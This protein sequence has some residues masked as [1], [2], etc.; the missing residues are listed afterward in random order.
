MWG[1]AGM[2]LA[3]LAVGIAGLTPS[4]AIAG[5]ASKS[6]AAQEAAIGQAGSVSPAP[7]AGTPQLYPTS[8][9]ETVRQ[10]VQCGGTMY[11]V[12]T[13]SEIAQGSSVYA[14]GNIFSFSATAPYQ[15]TSWNPTVNGTVNTIAF[16]GTDCSHA[17][18]GGSFTTV[19][20]TAAKNIAE[21]S[22]STGAVVSGWGHNANGTVRTLLAV[23]GHVLAGG[24]FTSINGSTK[25]PYYASLLTSTGLDD[26]YLNLQISGHLPNSS[27]TFVYNQ[28]LS[29]GGD[30]VLVEG[31]FTSVGGQSR[32]QIFMVSLN[33]TQGTVTGWTSTQFNQACYRTEPFY[34]RA[35]AWSPTDS[36]VYVADTGFHPA[37]WS[38]TFPLY[39]LCD[40]VAAFPS[41]EQTVSPH[42]INYTGCDSLYSVAADSST[43]Y[44]GGHERWADNPDGCNDGGPGSIRAPGLGGFT[45]ASGSLLLNSQGTA[46]LYSRARGHGADDLL[47]TTTGLWVASDNFDGSATCGGVSGHAGICFL[48]Y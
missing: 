41:S 12:G 18:I 21:I 25:H 1:G 37:N 5:T 48:P 46:G 6:A 32:Q 13:F 22:T 35:A 24:D 33:T 14:R 28:Q 39:G 20:G 10:L 40:A 19:N 47:L 9:T 16:N 30:R 44:V 7:A 26:G 11:A 43:V 29:H 27:S 17:Y 38:G 15:V 8:T 3:T 36:T 34:V 2:A 42:W 31:D 45:P 23:Q 4:A